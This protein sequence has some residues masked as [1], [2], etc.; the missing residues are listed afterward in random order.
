M[1]FLSTHPLTH[2]HTY[3]LLS[4]NAFEQKTARTFIQGTTISKR[5][6]ALHRLLSI[7]RLYI[8]KSVSQTPLQKLPLLSLLIMHST[9]YTMAA[10]DFF[11]H[12]CRALSNGS[13]CPGRI[14]VITNKCVAC[15]HTKCKACEPVGPPRGRQKLTISGPPCWRDF[16]R[17]YVL[18]FYSS[19]GIPLT[20]VINAELILCFLSTGEEVYCVTSR[21]RLCNDQAPD[22]IKH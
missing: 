16:R 18:C 11:F 15:K 13:P 8:T 17:Y 12:C 22:Q 14:S 9:T 3:S 19:G 6:F 1:Y 7:T 4:N 5:N 21:P 2:T 10:A 20:T